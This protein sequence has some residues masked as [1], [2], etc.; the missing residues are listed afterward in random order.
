MRIPPAFWIAFTVA[1][2]AVIPIVYIYSR[3][4]VTKWHRPRV[5]DIAVF[6]IFMTFTAVVASIAVVMIFGA[7]DFLENAKRPPKNPFEKKETEPEA[8]PQEQQPQG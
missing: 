3:K 7:E 8:D 1:M 5:G 6:S 4:G 2:L